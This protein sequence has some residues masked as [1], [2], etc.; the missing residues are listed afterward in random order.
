MAVRVTDNIDDIGRYDRQHPDRRGLQHIIESGQRQL[1]VMVPEETR[2]QHEG[3]SVPFI[4]ALRLEPFRVIQGGFR[5][6]H[7]IHYLFAY[8]RIQKEESLLQPNRLF[9]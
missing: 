8:N 5:F 6:C 7:Y 2:Q 1:S 3:T 4:V 9:S